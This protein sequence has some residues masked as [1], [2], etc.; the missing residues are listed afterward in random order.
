MESFQFRDKENNLYILPIER[1]K[2]DMKLE[3]GS[4]SKYRLYQYISVNRVNTSRHCTYLMLVT[5]AS[6]ILSINSIEAIENKT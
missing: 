2:R 4:A 5:E 6:L 1:D 3:N